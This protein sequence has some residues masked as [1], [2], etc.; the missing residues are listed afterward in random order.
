MLYRIIEIAKKT[1]LS[2]FLKH[3]ILGCFGMI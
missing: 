3:H 1:E 2:L